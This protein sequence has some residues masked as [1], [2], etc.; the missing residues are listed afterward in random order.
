MKSKERLSYLDFIRAIATIL[1][2]ICH[3]DAVFAYAGILGK[4]VLDINLFNI[5]IGN[6]GVS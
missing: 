1:I 2:V 3:Y 6:V 4:Y 5:Y